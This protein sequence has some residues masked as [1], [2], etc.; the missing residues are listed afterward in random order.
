MNRDEVFEQV[1]NE[2]SKQTGV[3]I[4]EVDKIID[5]TFKGLNM[6]MEDGVKQV[7]IPSLGLFRKKKNLKEPN[8]NGE[9]NS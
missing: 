2:A 6:F 9:P 4:L 5:A 3:N 7:R 8:G 1:K